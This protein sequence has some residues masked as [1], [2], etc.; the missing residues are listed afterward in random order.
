MGKTCCKDFSNNLEQNIDMSNELELIFIVGFAH[1]TRMKDAKTIHLE[2]KCRTSETNIGWIFTISKDNRSSLS[3]SNIIVVSMLSAYC[4]NMRPDLW[5]WKS[6]RSKR[7]CNN[8]C[9]RTGDNLKEGMPKQ[10]NF[11]HPR[12]RSRLKKIATSNNIRLI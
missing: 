4:Y 9:S 12:R 3:Q 6:H 7:I 10:L 2:N 8:L 11:Y 5:H 1:I